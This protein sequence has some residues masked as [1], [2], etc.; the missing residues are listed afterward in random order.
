MYII[1]QIIDD[2]VLYIAVCDVCGLPFKEE[3]VNHSYHIHH[4]CYW[5]LDIHAP[6]NTDTLK[7]LGFKEYDN[8]NI[9]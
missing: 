4:D 2:D 3:D 1:N 7:S 6:G 9:I 5:G 8:T